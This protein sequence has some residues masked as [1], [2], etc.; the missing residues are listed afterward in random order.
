MNLQESKKSISS[1]KRFKNDII[2]IFALMLII[3]VFG[4]IY[5]LARSAGNTVTVTVDGEFFA[6]Y[7]LGNDRTEEIHIGKNL[8]VLV[9]ES[10]KAYVKEASCPDGICS[11]HKPISRDGESIICIPNK[12]VITISTK[13][14][15]NTPDIIV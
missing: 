7:P 6:E 14:N 15:A 8:N 9:I 1:K 3:S 12:V 5:F 10:G 4:S 11:S 2:F 13:S